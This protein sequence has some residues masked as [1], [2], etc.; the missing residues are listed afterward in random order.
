M[1][2]NEQTMVL[3]LGRGG[4]SLESTSPIILVQ[5]ENLNIHKATVIFQ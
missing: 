5:G 3:F 2:G 1:A 4:L